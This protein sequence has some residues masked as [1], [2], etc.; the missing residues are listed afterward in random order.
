MK[1]PKGFLQ[2][3]ASVS[4]IVCFLFA[5]ASGVLLYLHEPEAD[6][7][8][9]ISGSLG[10]SIFFFFCVGIVLTIIGRSDLPSFKIDSKS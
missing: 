1:K 4:G 10:A 5:I 9:P 3:T 2:K 7:L 8:D 6:R